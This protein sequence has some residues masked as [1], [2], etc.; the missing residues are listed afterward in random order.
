[1]RRIIDR[2]VGFQ[3]GPYRIGKYEVTRG[4]FKRFLDETGYRFVPLPS[5]AFAPE[6]S[7]YPVIGASWEDAQAF[8]MW[9]SGRERAVYR[10]PSEAE[11]E[12]AARGTQGYREPW[13]NDRGRE[14]VDA[15]WGRLS[16]LTSQVPPVRPVGSF[17]RDRSPFGAFDM[18]GNVK[19][20]CLDE[21]D[22]TYYAWSPAV[23]PFGPVEKT[24][25]KVQRGGSWNDPGPGDFAIRRSHAGM[26]QRYT[27]NGFRVLREVDA[28]R[29][30]QQA[31]LTPQ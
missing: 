21:Y 5:D 29:H 17:L 31:T 2:P 9:Q 15:N 6:F 22:G 28:P 26:N 16:E 8:T 12:L 18:A 1:V 23:N 24:G 11:W 27:G 3:V 14:G 30:S 7:D 20:W 19:E 13:G 4:Q 10:L 25:S